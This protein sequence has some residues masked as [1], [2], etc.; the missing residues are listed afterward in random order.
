MRLSIDDMIF[1][2]KKRLE[3]EKSMHKKVLL[4]QTLELLSKL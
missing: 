2:L 1:E 3:S 4:K